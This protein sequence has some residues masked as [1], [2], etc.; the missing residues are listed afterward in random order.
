MEKILQG[1][2]T[3]A[4]VGNLMKRSSF[5]DAGLRRE[6][7]QLRHIRSNRYSP[8]VIGVC[9]DGNGSSRSVNIIYT[10][11]EFPEGCYPLIGIGLWA[12]I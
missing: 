6:W 3:S 9:S 8:S 7:D 4:A 1:Y 10:S 5:N 11:F 12:P 2:S